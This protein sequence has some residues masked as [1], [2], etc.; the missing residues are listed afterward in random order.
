MKEDETRKKYNKSYSPYLK[1][2][3]RH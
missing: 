2:P 1:L 3:T